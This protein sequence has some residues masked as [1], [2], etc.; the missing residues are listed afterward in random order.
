MNMPRSFLLQLPLYEAEPI[1]TFTQRLQVATK[2][3]EA[4][5]LQDWYAV[6]FVSQL[7]DE[8]ARKVGLVGK[9]ILHPLPTRKLANLHNIIGSH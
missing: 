3:C 4:R 6:Q 8:I 9:V 5:S 2:H 7:L 1:S